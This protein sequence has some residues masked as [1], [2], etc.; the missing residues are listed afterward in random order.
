MVTMERV[1]EDGSG[2]PAVVSVR[3]W[4]YACDFL[5]DVTCALITECSSRRPPKWAAKAA[6]EQYLAE[7]RSRAPANWFD[8]NRAMYAK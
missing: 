7:L 8:A 5:G 3:G 4:T 2:A 1:F 6:R